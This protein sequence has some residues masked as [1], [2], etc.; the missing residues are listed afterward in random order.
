MASDRIPDALVSIAGGFATSLLTIIAIHQFP[1][2]GVPPGIYPSVAV[3]TLLMILLVSVGASLLCFVYIIFM[4]FHGYFFVNAGYVTF[5][6]AASVSLVGASLLRS[7]FTRSVAELRK[8][9]LPT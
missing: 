3:L 5:G 2:L 8:R 9:R 1:H 4:F 7:I 6:M